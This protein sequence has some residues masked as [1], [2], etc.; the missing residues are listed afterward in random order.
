[1]Q[2][3]SK[4]GHLVPQTLDRSVKPNDT[5][6]LSVELPIV[7][8]DDDWWECEV[9]VNQAILE[10]KRGGGGPVHINL[11]T[12]YSRSYDTKT[13][14]T[15]RVMNRFNT[16]D[17][18][19]ELKGRVAVFIGAHRPFSAQETE[20]LDRFCSSNNAVVFCDHTSCYKGK[21][22]L[23]YSLAAS[24]DQMDLAPYKP[25]VTIHIG[26][27][28]GDYAGMGMVGKEVWRVSEDGEIRDTFRKLRYVFE[29]DEKT[30]FERYTDS[31]KAP[32]DQYL[33]HCQARL[34]EVQQEIPEI[35]F[36]NIWVAQQTAHRI[37]EGSVVHFGILNS[38][39]SWNFFELPKS[40]T[41]MSNV[42]GFGI[43]GGLS[44]LLGASLADPNKLYFCII[45]DL[46]FFYDM[47]ALG[48]R[49]VGNNLRIMVINNGKGT[50]FRQYN[51]VAAHFG[52][53]ADEFISASG[54]YGNKSPTLI[55]HY[56]QDLGFKYLS[57]SSKDDY[58]AA[59]REF[60]AKDAGGRSVV[61][62]VFT[63]SEEESRALEMIRNIKK[64]H[65]KSAKAAARRVLGD[66]SVNAMKKFLKS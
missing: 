58:E 5:H 6:R 41:S 51:H 38:L 7:K 50:E 13:L 30:F 8:D 62:E 19:P 3:L 47:N 55:K 12:R 14:P 37:P 21:Y 65:K 63:D 45:G 15:C 46:A 53:Q 60:L 1:M 43:D 61:F 33:K 64:D 34:K 18:L 2:L 24:Q 48:N 4:V 49:H 66:R 26:E 32:S 40:V 16:T 23:L 11:P 10:L 44:S 25:D 54:H 29:M 36:S 52:D 27:V 28:T 22:R 35:P 56:A 39:R 57:A 59:Y 31:S 42:G 9:K 20:A 17:K